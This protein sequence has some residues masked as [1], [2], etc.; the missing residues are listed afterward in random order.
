MMLAGKSDAGRYI[1]FARCL[2]KPAGRAAD[3]EGGVGGQ[4]YLLE[5]LHLPSRYIRSRRAKHMHWRNRD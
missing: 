5:E 2:R 1:V 4:R 3:L